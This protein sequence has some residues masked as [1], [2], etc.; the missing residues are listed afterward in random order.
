[1]P[2]RISV[3]LRI[4]LLGAL[5][6]GALTAPA[7]A[8]QDT[9]A[10]AMLERSRDAV[11]ALKS[12]SYAVIS[13]RRV[14]DQAETAQGIVRF[15]RLGEGDAIG[16]KLRVEGQFDGK[17]P[18]GGDLKFKIT[19]DGEHVLGILG[20]EPKLWRGTAE[21]AE[22]ILMFSEALVVRGLTSDEVLASD[23]AAEEVTLGMKS[24]IDGVEVIAI[25][26]QHG[27]A[28]KYRKA[29]WHVGVE[30]HLPRMLVAD[31]HLRGVALNEVQ[32]VTDL[33][34]NPEIFPALFRL[35]APVGFTV[36]DY[37]SPRRTGPVLLPVGSP[38]PEF[39]LEDAEG[40]AHK[41][42]D[43][44]GKIVVI[45]FW[46][47][48]CPPCRRAMPLVEKLHQRFLEREDVVVLGIA[49]SERGD[50]DPAKFMRD[51]G[52]TYG[53]L[54]NGERIAGEYLAASLPTFYVI[55][56]D[57]K[58]LHASVGFESDLDET[59]GKLIESKL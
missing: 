49:T 25:E 56:K 28:G 2:G 13:E 35:N 20:E 23:A 7:S 15:E 32:R 1:M 33:I 58:V 6:V 52:F 55:G 4:T 36:E 27:E 21:T 57:G 11:A 26:C 54:L 31:Y 46:A 5:L 50:S 38:A 51:A 10:R 41:L 3:M 17:G 16:T 59:I 9:D 29:V 18:G 44:R 39:T 40:K 22:D 30:D 8:T 14:G 42:S 43:Y 34:A 45:D 19:Y 12:G 48:W 24:E 53:L 37:V 47:T